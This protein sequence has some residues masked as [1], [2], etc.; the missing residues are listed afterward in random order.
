MLKS[1]LYYL[2]AVLTAVRFADMIY[3]LSADKTNLPIPVLVVTSA[4]IVFGLYLVVK[5]FIGV[6]LL[7]QMTMFY[8][9]NTVAILFN[10][11]YT[12]VTSPFNITFLETIITGTFLD[13][14]ISVALLGM[15]IKRMRAR[16]FSAG[17][18]FSDKRSINV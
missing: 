14:I 15:C 9:F 8:L 11:I 2:T 4:M 3:L 17:P 7:R 1:V 5:K 10:L 18:E 16:Y 12:A 13:V 6:I